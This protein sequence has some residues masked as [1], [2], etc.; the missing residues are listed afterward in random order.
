MGEFGP[1]CTAACWEP[2]YC[3]VCG[4]RKAPRG[5]SVALEAAN[6]FCDWECS[7]YRLD[8]RPGHLWPNEAPDPAPSTAQLGEGR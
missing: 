6:G 5:R 3:T 1:D 4:R 8:P 2:V 7:G